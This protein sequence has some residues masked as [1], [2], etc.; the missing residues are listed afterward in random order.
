M[1]AG[2]EVIANDDR[3]LALALGCPD[4]GRLD[5]MFRIE[6]GSASGSVP[7]GHLLLSSVGWRVTVPV[8][9][10]DPAL[11]RQRAWATVQS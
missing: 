2:A 6:L 7:T 10:S 9:T 1:R 3:S 8:H 4:D 5:R 11:A